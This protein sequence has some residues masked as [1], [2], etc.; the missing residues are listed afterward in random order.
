MNIIYSHQVLFNMI[1]RLSLYI[2]GIT[3]TSMHWSERQEMYYI[4]LGIYLI[5]ETILL[6]CSMFYLLWKYN[7]LTIPNY[8]NWTRF[9]SSRVYTVIVDDL[10]EQQQQGTNNNRR[11]R[12][13]PFQFIE[14]NERI[15]NICILIILTIIGLIGLLQGLYYKHWDQTLIGLTMST[16]LFFQ[17]ICIMFNI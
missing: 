12:F 8:S 3:I 15:V 2:I 13:Y 5:I 4:W 17:F 16:S 1:I 10:E 11:C 7:R 9:K 6:T 14:Q